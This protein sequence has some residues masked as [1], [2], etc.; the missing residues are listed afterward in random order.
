MKITNSLLGIGLLLG[1]TSAAALSLGEVRGSV[2]LG[3]PLDVRFDVQPD[4]GMA[5]DPACLTASAAAG[6]TRIDSSRM[7]ISVVPAV[8]GRATA[9]Y[10][11]TSPS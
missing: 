2:V 5:L 1:A 6:D 4:P 7:Q 10:W 8:A 11:S 9:V 3:R